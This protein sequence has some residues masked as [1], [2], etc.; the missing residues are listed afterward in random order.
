MSNHSFRFLHA[1]GLRLHEPLRGIPEV[2]EAFAALL[3]EAPY[4]SAAAVF[5]AAAREEV[6]FVV[7]SGDLL[8]PTLAGPRAIAF[9]QSEFA[10]LGERG[11][12]VYWAASQRDLAG[13]WLRTIEWPENLHLFSS[14]EVETLMHYR[15]N[16]PLA[17]ILGRSWHASRPLRGTEFKSEDA[18]HF[19]VAVLPGHAEIRDE[20]E[21]VR[22][23]AFGGQRAATP[24]EG[25]S[26]GHCPGT[27]Q[28]TTPSE[29][30]LHGCALVHAD[31]DGSVRTRMLPTDA[32]RWCHE[33]LPI[34]LAASRQEV[35]Q[36][37]RSRIKHLAAEINR[38]TLVVW[39]LTG[40]NRFDSLFVQSEDRRE[41][42]EWLRTEFADATPPLWSVS[43]ELEPP[44][45]LPADWCEEDSILGDYL[46]VVQKYESDPEARLQLD[47]DLPASAPPELARLLASEDPSQRNQVLQDAALLGADLL[48]GDD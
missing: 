38:P 15:A 37:L 17:E 11:I 3:T 4:V 46:R 33:R 40:D 18:E 42:L 16:T 23:W 27:T 20:R 26:L 8:D 35:R 41:M 1:C 10:K 19:R 13:D 22:Y 6:D 48:R 45:E 12:R 44:E 2:D 34:S 47:K 7:L 31:A 28:G 43:L 14:D 21:G 29:T 32:V 30:G 5:A 36:T 25:R 24:F 9:L 39:T